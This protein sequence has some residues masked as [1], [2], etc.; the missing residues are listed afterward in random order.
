MDLGT[1]KE[2][3]TEVRRITPGRRILI[4]GSSSLLASF[5]GESPAA[6]GVEL[7]LDADLFLD[8]DDEAFRVKLTETL[9][10]DR[11]FHE[12][13]GHYGDF[14]DLRLADSF[15]GG[16]RDRLVPMPGFPDVFAID[17]T[18]MAVTKVV[19]TAHSRWSLRMGRSNADRGRKDIHTIV[20]LLKAR[21]IDR[22]ALVERLALL[23]LPPALI[24]E[25]AGVMADID[26]MA[27]QR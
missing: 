15:P 8:P 7:T 6:I 2:L 26:T 9:G 11:P 10:R 25:C 12:A 18:D 22:T 19:A 27:T 20:A 17:P 4:F 16:W 13:T 5:P 21:R 24:A 23:E 14:V 1:L 3:L